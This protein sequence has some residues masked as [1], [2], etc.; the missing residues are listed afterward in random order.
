MNFVKPKDPSKQPKRIFCDDNYD[1][2][3][4]IYN[5]YK[6]FEANKTNAKGKKNTY[7]FHFELNDDIYI[8]KFD[9]DTY[10]YIYE[11]NLI[12]GKKF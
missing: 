11:I 5:Y 2:E 6:I 7:K 3:K 12:Y 9:A 8:I 1:V 4:N 10:T